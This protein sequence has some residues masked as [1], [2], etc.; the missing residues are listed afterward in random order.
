M[1]RYCEASVLQERMA[2]HVHYEE[3]FQRHV[4]QLASGSS[5]TTAQRLQL[6]LIVRKLQFALDLE[7]GLRVMLGPVFKD[8]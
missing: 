7:P 3:E 5:V 1:H 8:L 6:A 4:L 2:Q